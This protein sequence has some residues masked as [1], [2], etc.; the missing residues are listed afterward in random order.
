MVARLKLNNPLNLNIS[1][2]GGKDIKQDLTSSSERNSIIGTNL[3]SANEDDGKHKDIH[4]SFG[5]LGTI[6]LKVCP[7]QLPNP[8]VDTWKG[9][10]SKGLRLD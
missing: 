6:L 4:S 8:V 3:D 2:S 7:E 1:I 10:Y 9:S 5:L